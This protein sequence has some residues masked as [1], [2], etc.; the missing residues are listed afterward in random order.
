VIAGV[1][2]IQALC[3][4]FF[5]SDIAA[6]VLGIQ[7]TP[8]AWELRELMEIGAALG[9]ILGLLLGA[10]MLRSTIRERNDAREL[11]IARGDCDRVERF[12]ERDRQLVGRRPQGRRYREV[13]VDALEEIV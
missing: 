4:V 12:R 9:L 13:G 6:S 8:I 1:L 3:A 11:V 7:T 5:V 2:L 10:W